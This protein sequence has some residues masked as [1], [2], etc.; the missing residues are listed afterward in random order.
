[1]RYRH[2]AF[3]I[4]GVAAMLTGC[5]GINGTLLAPA[6]AGLTA[7]PTPASVKYATLY[8]FS[9]RGKIGA[10]PYADL[11]AVD[12]TLY[13]AAS[14]GGAYA[15]GTVFTI[16]TSGK[17]TT[18]HSFHGYDGVGP[19]AGLVDVKG[20]LYGTTIGGGDSG[21]CGSST[22]CGTVFSI[23]PS[24]KQTVLHNFSGG[25]DGAEPE[26]DLI[27]VKDTLYS[28]TP[29]GG[30]NQR[31]TVFAIT[32]SGKERVLH[33]FGGQA[34]GSVPR[35]GLIDLDGTLY[36]TT[37]GGG[38]SGGCSSTGCG[39]VFSITTSGNEKVLHRFSG[40][41]DGVAPFGVL[42][43]VN[44]MLYGT[45]ASGGT[46]GA[47]T[48]FSITPSGK[49]A[50]LYSFKGGKTDGAHPLAGLTDVNGTLYGTTR[51][52]GVGGYGTVFSIT[53]SGK[54]TV[55]HSF[56]RYE[57]GQYPNA[58]LL[59]DNGTLYGTTSYGGT[60]TYGTVFSLKP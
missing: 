34:D 35:A 40:G 14:L 55:L 4:I 36:G 45:T 42:I 31:G 39:T 46:S 54:E 24:G 25:G 33:D 26:A 20:T 21:S 9:G 56:A 8:S 5:G 52:D 23:T 50:V 41:T 57:D 29:L 58:G 19:L 3:G 37:S 16:T 49:E 13:G 22:Y 10:F 15:D 12:G 17:E 11:I 27:D 59:D 2:Y 51:N 18:L 48:V 6:P 44:G 7:A 43:D 38:G 1:M 53:L 28:T 60:Y 47:G 32:T 30:A